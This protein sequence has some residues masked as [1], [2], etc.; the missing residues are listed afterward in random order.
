MQVFSIETGK[1]KLDG[2]AMFGVV[3][4]SIWNKTN[5][6]DENNLATWALRCLLVIDGERKILIDTGMGNKQDAKFFSHYHPH[7]TIAITTALKNINFTPEDITDVLLTHLHFDHVGGAIVKEKEQYV[8]SFPNAIYWVSEPQWNL[9]LHPNKRE[10]ASFLPENI[11]PIEAS[12]QLKLISLPL[13]TSKTQL[14]EI[15]F[16]PS[17]SCY[18]VNGHT[19]GMLI[20]K[21]TFNNHTL[22][23]M[24]DLLPSVGHIPLPYVMGYDMQPL[25]TLEEKEIFL[26]EA[27][28]NNYTLFFEHDTVNECCNLAMTEKGIRANKTFKLTT[29]LS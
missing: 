8:P 27:E 17:I 14:Q 7:E 11:L 29:L 6:A 4:K 16:S 19:Q 3:P 15:H 28:K 9:A 2:G 10:K 25:I 5:P 12:R 24:A 20:P 26:K 22:V 1:F 18:V 21:I 23:F 13:F